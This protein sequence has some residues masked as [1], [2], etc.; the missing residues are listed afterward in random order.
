M[1]ATKRAF[2]FLT[3]LV[4][5]CVI[6]ATAVTVSAK[7]SAMKKGKTFTYGNYKYKVTKLKGKSGEVALIGATSKSIAS[8]TV[9][10]TV[11]SGKYKFQV[12]TIGDKAFQNYKKLISL[13][14]N[15]ELKSIGKNAFAGC[16]KL[17]H[18]QIPGTKLSK[19]GKNAFKGTGPNASIVVPDAKAGAYANLLKG[20]G[21]KATV[22]IQPL[23]AYAKSSNNKVVA[24]SSPV[25]VPAPAPQTEHTHS[26]SAWTVTKYATCTEAGSETCLCSCGAMQ[27]R[28]IP[29]LGHTMVSYPAVA[30]TCTAAGR[31]AYTACSYCGYTE[32][33]A[34]EIPAQG[35]R[36]GEWSVTKEASCAACGEETRKCS[37]CGK[38]ETKSTA[39]LEHEMVEA[40]RTSATCEQGGLT[41]YGCT[42]C[43]QIQVSINS[44][45]LGHQWAETPTVVP[46]TCTADGIEYTACLRDGCTA[47][48]GVKLLPRLREHQWQRTTVEATCTT[49]GS[50]TDTCA[51]CGETKTQTV[52]ALGHKF[53][54]Y[55][56]DGNASCVEA[57]TVTAKCDRCGI[58]DTKPGTTANLT[59]HTWV[60]DEEHSKPAICV[61][62]GIN[63]YYCANENCKRTKTEVVEADGHHWT[64]TGNIS[65]DA[66]TGIWAET[67]CSVCGL[68]SSGKLKTAG[69]GHTWGEGDQQ[70]TCTVCGYNPKKFGAND[71]EQAKPYRYVWYVRFTADMDQCEGFVNEKGYAVD[72]VMP[73]TIFDDGY[74][75]K[76]ESTGSTMENNN[77]LT[78]TAPAA[79]SGYT[80]AGWYCDGQL[81][82]SSR[83]ITR[84]WRDMYKTYEARYT[85]AA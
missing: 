81:A 7:G 83:T 38:K 54:N 8:V 12:T 19:I 64:E 14:T 75:W 82:E 70:Y 72:T 23:K 25:S 27:T 61:E 57:G 58:A 59:E 6:A 31:T 41:Y 29:A 26:Y 69:T 46:A 66:C 22:Q 77:V 13:K 55:V 5:I 17:T 52:R 79:K 10:N 18:I 50:I 73:S 60:L 37:A 49:A 78:M 48:K 80:F 65:G 20:K 3:A 15:A 40:G 84:T 35:H 63:K 68:R 53:T 36:F 33:A 28:E 43:H 85:P 1:K 56:P 74:N 2:Q 9:P 4:L 51:V 76:G 11:K 67:E 44:Q 34:Q 71:T 47:R 39:K 24:A 32:T 30:A 42:K 16:G 21:Q 45:P 62:A